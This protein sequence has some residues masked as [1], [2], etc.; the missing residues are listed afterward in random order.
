MGGATVLMASGEILPA[1]VKCVVEDCGYTSVW[2]IFTYQLKQLFHLPAFPVMYIANTT[3]EMRAGFDM[4]K[5][6]A[7]EQVKKSSVPIMFIHGD[8]DAFVP[9]EMVYPL[10]EAKTRGDRELLIV[11]GAQHGNALYVN[12]EAYMEAALGFIARYMNTSG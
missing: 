3:V 11:D 4:R 2:D 7:V 8:K 5:A 6:S 9:F 1:N 10:Y 12:R